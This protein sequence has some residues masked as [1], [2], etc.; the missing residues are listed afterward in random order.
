MPLL[1]ARIA[2]LTTPVSTRNMRADPLPSA[3]AIGVSV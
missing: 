2:S 1:N 3:S